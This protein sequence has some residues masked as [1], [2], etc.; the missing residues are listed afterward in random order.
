MHSIINKN[1]VITKKAG[2]IWKLS[3]LQAAF[4]CLT[5]VDV[6]FVFSIISLHD[7]TKSL[8]KYL[9]LFLH[10][11]WFIGFLHSHRHLPL[12]NFWFKLHLLLNLQLPLREIC[13]VIV[14]DWS[15]FVVIL[16]IFKSEYFFY[17]AHIFQ[18]A[19]H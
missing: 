15:I 2:K 11:W 8:P 9:I 18:L 4:L 19:S 12:F 13:F 1:M 10:A 3:I 14:S 7:A 6:F 16:K 17:L 5:F